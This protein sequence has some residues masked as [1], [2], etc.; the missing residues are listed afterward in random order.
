MNALPPRYDFLVLGAGPAGQKSAIQAARAGRKVLLVDR[1]ARAG[2]ECVHRG[3]IP[4][5][6][7][8]ESAL[9]L[10][11]LKQRS[12]G[13]VPNGLGPQTKVES[14]MKR[15]HHVLIAHEGYI[16]RQLDRVGIERRRGRARFVDPHTV[17][18]TAVGGAKELVQADVIVV[19][20][21]SRPRTPPEIPVDHEHILD[22]DSIL[23]LIY[24]PESLVVL[25]AGVIACEFATIFQAL[26]VKVTM[27]DRGARP[28]AFLDQEI[29]DLFVQQF[30]R[31][32]GRFVA[33]QK[34]EA[35]EHDGLS[36]CHVR[37]AS[38]EVLSAEKVLVALGRTACLSGLD[39]QNAG[40][41]PTDRGFLQVDANCRTSVEHIYGAGDVIGPPALAASSME[42]GRRATRHALGVPLGPAQDTI[43]AGI[44]TIPEMSCVG[45]TEADA[46]KRFGSALVG[47]ARFDELARGQINGETEGLVKLI[48][49]PAGERLVG[50]QILGEGATELI[51]LAQMAIVGNLPITTF[52]EN[53]FNFPTLAEA[54]RVAAL[55][56]LEQRARVRLA[57]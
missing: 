4:S 2:G 50:A 38:G 32:G 26:G 22:S 33:G 43:P 28:L 21:G 30:E 37:L 41:A 56:V 19:A 15:L 54:Y 7:L 55:D 25:G 17:E 48:C 14:L 23:S 40:L 5:K 27:V 53:V 46:I 3:T 11:G 24:L 34:H 36:S 10:A 20:T 18:I 31:M 29:T 39:V 57:S 8:R 42:Q 1:E 51:H 13:F 49:D 6:T 45:L 16:G 44:Y 52:V 9:Y 35:V 12:V 47:R